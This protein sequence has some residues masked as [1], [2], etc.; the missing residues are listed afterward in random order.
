MD[1]HD[2]LAYVEPRCEFIEIKP[3]QMIAASVWDEAPDID[4]GWVF[5]F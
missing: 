3:K 1:K 4:E 2:S 5:D